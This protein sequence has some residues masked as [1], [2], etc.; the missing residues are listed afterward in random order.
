MDE[1]DYWNKSEIKTFDFDEDDHFETIQLTNDR[2]LFADE[3]TS[4]VSYDHSYDLPSSE[5]PLHLLISDVDLRKGN[6]Q[7]VCVFF[8]NLRL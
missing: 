7:F 5:I 1:E 3:S 2:K 4:E 8:F 6:S